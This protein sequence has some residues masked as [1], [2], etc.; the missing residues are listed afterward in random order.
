ML[1]ANAES[2]VF[3]QHIPWQ[4]QEIIPFE[5]ADEFIVVHVDHLKDFAQ[6]LLVLC[7]EERIKLRLL[8][9]AVVVGVKQ[10]EVLSHE[11]FETSLI[12]DQG[13]Q[14]LHQMEIKL[15]LFLLKKAFGQQLVLADFSL[16]DLLARQKV[17]WPI[18]ELENYVLLQNSGPIRIALHLIVALLR[19]RYHND[20]WHERYQDE[21]DN[22]NIQYKIRLLRHELCDFLL[23]CTEFS[24]FSFFFFL[25]S[26]S[27]FQAI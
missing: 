14:A 24:F 4:V 10:N 15:V 7:L 5:L 17:S 1:L 26:G 9:D 20:G 13:L 23:G 12:L 11:R 22:Q 18:V 16:A 2:E 19:A 8:D 6:V 3:K 25:C 27:A 21:P